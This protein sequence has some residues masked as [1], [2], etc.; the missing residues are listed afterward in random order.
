MGTALAVDGFVIETVK[1]DAKD[2]NGQQ[3]L[4][5]RN[6]K[7]I[8]GLISQVP[9]DVNAN[10]RFV[11]TDWPGAT[12]DLSFSRETA[13][14]L[15]LKNQQLPH[16][17]YTIGDEAYSPLSAECNGQILTPYSQHQLNAVKQNYWQNRQ[18]WEECIA[19]DGDLAVDKPVEDYWKIRAFNH[20]LSSER[21]TIENARNDGETIWN[22]LAAHGI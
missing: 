15:L 9:C 16:W 22:S 6:R 7:G 11:Q 12:N 14:F 1:P 8:W 5:Y 10:V 20:E 4:C 21:I 13:L 2:L 3:V 18:D 17:M 19:N